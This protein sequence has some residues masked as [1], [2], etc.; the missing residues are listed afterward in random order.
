METIEKTKIVVPEKIPAQ[1]SKKLEMFG[2]VVD[3]DFVFAGVGKNGTR[4]ISTKSFVPSNEKEA[5]AFV[6]KPCLKGFKT[7]EG[8][9]NPWVWY[10]NHKGIVFNDDGT[11]AIVLKDQTEPTIYKVEHKMILYNGE[12]SNRS[13]IT[14]FRRADN[15]SE[16]SELPYSL[17][18]E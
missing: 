10:L 11:I 2:E 13:G 6:I 8:Y 4:H 18:E 1:I 15:D 16:T 12:L 17:V 9:R 7:A 3:V 14:T 5:K